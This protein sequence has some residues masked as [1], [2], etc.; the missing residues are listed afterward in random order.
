MRSILKR[1]LILVTAAAMILSGGTAAFGETA[2]PEDVRIEELMNAF[3]QFWSNNDYNSMLELSDPE[4][5]ANCENP[6]NMLFN[7]VGNRTALEMTIEQIAEDGNGSDGTVTAEILMDRNDGKEPVRY[8]SSI[9]VIKRADGNW[10]ID[11]K[12]LKSYEVTENTRTEAMDEAI[13]RDLLAVFFGGWK[14]SDYD[15]MLEACSPEW[16]KEQENAKQNLFILLAN[17]TALEMTIEQ[18][19]E[20]EAGPDRCAAVKVLMD[21]NNGRDPVLYRLSVLV[22]KDPDGNWYVDPESLKSVEVITEAAA[23]TENDSAAEAEA[24]ER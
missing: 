16:T 9:H 11:P 18:I 2:D 13:I 21:R 6:R 20:E 12:S 3:Y 14:S 1:F 17:R 24:P 23:G 19:A 7:L 15:L 8:R 4:W 5:K 10:Y 22:T